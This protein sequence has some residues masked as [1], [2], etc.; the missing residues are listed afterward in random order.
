MKKLYILTEERFPTLLEDD[1][2]FISVFKSHDI[3]AIP[4]VWDQFDVKENMNV[5]IR[6]VWDYPKKPKQFIKLINEIESK[7]GRCF[8]STETIN[9]NINKKYLLELEN[10]EINIV[11][12][13]ISDSFKLTELKDLD[14]PLVVKPLVGAGGAHTYLLKSPSQLHDVEV[15]EDTAVIIQPF[16]ESIKTHGEY[17]FIYF[18]DKFS[19]AVV[20]T[21]DDSEFRIQEIHGGVVKRYNPSDD[22]INEITEYLKKLGRHFNY[23]RVD[24]VKFKGHFAIMELEAFEP[25]LFFRFSDNGVENLCNGLAKELQ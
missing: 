5:L 24:V 12:T 1:K 21:N 11:P 25:E 22:E 13:K 7:G 14:F 9:W 2:D 6:S 16:I 15:L 19:H 20:K 18:G 10:L 8:N 23:V 3:E 17:S 4:V